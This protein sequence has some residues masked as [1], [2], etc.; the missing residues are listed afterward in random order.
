M[1]QLFLS[2]L[3]IVVVF[4]F[5]SLCVSLS[6]TGLES[7]VKECVIFVCRGHMKPQSRADAPQPD[8]FSGLTQNLQN[9]GTGPSSDCITSSDLPLSPNENG[10]NDPGT[11]RTRLVYSHER[12][13]CKYD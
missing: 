8:M 2:A 5:F 1:S 11:S 7:P 9:P 6:G 13:Q 12:A 4:F 3:M 10:L